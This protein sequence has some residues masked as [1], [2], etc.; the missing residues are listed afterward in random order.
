M[1]ITCNVSHLQVT[2]KGHDENFR[3]FNNWILHEIYNFLHLDYPMQ[4]NTRSKEISERNDITDDGC[5]RW[6]GSSLIYFAEQY[7]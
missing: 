6:L 1:S 5:L 4:T 7:K 3:F 2:T